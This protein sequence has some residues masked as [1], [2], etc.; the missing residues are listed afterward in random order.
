M[1]A[2]LILSG[3]G[4]QAQT[5]TLLDE[6]FNDN[7]AN[8]QTFD[9]AYYAANISGGKYILECKKNYSKNFYKYFYINPKKDFYV[10]MQMT[11]LSQG[12]KNYGCGLVWGSSYMKQ[13]YFDISKTGYYTIYEYNGYTKKSTNIQAWENSDLVN[14]LGEA[15]VLAIE[16]KGNTLNFFLNGVVVFNMPFKTFFGSN[17]GFAVA[18]NTKVSVD[19]FLVRSTKVPIYLVD[20]PSQGYK[21]ENLGTNINSM[22][23]ELHPLISQDGKTLFFTRDDHPQNIGEKKRQDVWF[24]TMQ[25]DGAWGKA[26]NIGSPINTEGHNSGVYLS[27]DNNT[28]LM[29]MDESDKIGDKQG[30]Y[31]SHRT[32]NGWSKPVEVKIDN[33]YNYNRYE[34]QCISADGNTLIMGIERED[35]H[36]GTDLYVCYR[37]GA[38]SWSEPK[39]MGS[40]LNTFADDFTPFLAADGKTLYF[41]SSGHPG[42][43]SADIYVSKRLDDTWVN[44]SK[45]QNL[46]SE[47]NT[48]DWDAYYSVAASGEDAFLISRGMGG[49]SDIFK[50]KLAETDKPDPVVMI[51]GRVYDANTKKPIAAKILYEDL[52]TAKQAG[53]ARSN[54]K[55]G[56]YKVVLPYGTHYGLHAEAKNY[57]AIS[58]NINIKEKKDYI[59]IVRDLYLAPIKVGQTVKLQNVFFK[60]GTPNLLDNSFPELDRLVKIMKE[61]PKIEIELAGHTDGVGSPVIL[62]KLSQARIKTVVDYLLE[63]GVPESRVVGKGYGGTKPV[64]SNK[65]EETRKLNRRVEFKILKF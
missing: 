3:L 38:N 40:V 18:S 32:L 7:K 14:D 2:Y 19:Y 4:L 45:P 61:N 21:K 46:G 42:Y 36:G 13:Y 17:V 52:S 35:T 11:M 60:R 43:G 34:S 41:A 37:K 5:R 54:P 12:E 29:D 64:A 9:G 59:E 27:A 28:F 58:E 8:W 30:I 26:E 55:N 25:G 16:K 23:D 49:S 62:L 33:Y 53:I 39:N 56:R 44:W 65:T 57:I 15:N 47:I 63:K 31:E 1:F 6:Q 50:I 51:S 20:A 10:E 24:S 22:T 48:S